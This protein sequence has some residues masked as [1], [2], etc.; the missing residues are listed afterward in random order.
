MLGWKRGLGLAGSWL[1]TQE[2]PGYWS[3]DAWSIVTALSIA[4]EIKTIKVLVAT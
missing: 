4:I 1:V 2:L 3:G